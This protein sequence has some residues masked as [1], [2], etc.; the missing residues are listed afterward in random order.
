MPGTATA[1]NTRFQTINPSSTAA[2]ATEPPTPTPIVVAED[3]LEV[4]LWLLFPDPLRH[5]LFEPV[6]RSELAV[7]STASCL[8]LP[9]CMQPHLERWQFGNEVQR[10]ANTV[11]PFQ[12]SG[13]GITLYLNDRRVVGDDKREPPNAVLVIPGNPCLMYGGLTIWRDLMAAFKAVGITVLADKLSRVDICADCPGINMQHFVDAYDQGRYISRAHQ[14]D[15]H[16]SNG[17]TLTFGNST[18]M[19]R[20]YD[21]RAEMQAR[22]TPITRQL[23][24]ETRWGGV[25]PVHAIRAEYQLRRSVLHK[26]WRITTFEDYVD[27]RPHIINDLLIWTRFT[28][29][30]PNK[31]NT[32]RELLDPVWDRIDSAFCQ[33]AGEPVK[34]LPAKVSMGLP[35]VSRSVRQSLGHLITAA[36]MAIVGDKPPRMENVDDLITFFNRQLRRQLAG[37]DV[38]KLLS[39]RLHKKMSN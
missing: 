14:R 39:E 8:P 6:D 13:Q 35:D 30:A 17:V 24:K 5:I 28:R 31:T 20:I 3:W 16:E 12:L 29:R 33:W 25:V 10:R 18:Q 32:I 38:R 23:M 36:A 7:S 15:K 34:P 9:A 37:A 4:H 11:F 19:L 26:K 22:D 1:C 21:K 2:T 27:A